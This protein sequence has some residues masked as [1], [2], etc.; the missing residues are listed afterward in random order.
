MAMSLSH[1][2]TE[3]CIQHFQKLPGVETASRPSVGW[4][5]GLGEVSLSRGRKANGKLQAWAQT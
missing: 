2:K 5:P 3:A 4:L 1:I